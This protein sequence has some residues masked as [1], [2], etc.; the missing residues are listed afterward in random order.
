MPYRSTHSVFVV[1]VKAMTSAG[2]ALV[3]E[4]PAQHTVRELWELHRMTSRKQML[5]Q[6]L[7][8]FQLLLTAIAAP[9][10]KLAADIIHQFHLLVELQI[11]MCDTENVQEVVAVDDVVRQADAER[12]LLSHLA[13]T[14]TELILSERLRKVTAAP[15]YSC[16]SA[17]LQK[18]R[19]KEAVA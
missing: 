19:E 2:G 8:V 6:L 1:T 4:N 18:C 17:T 7:L 10:V 5:K 14:F 11:W 15:F 12:V 16:S 13:M 3:F 9:L